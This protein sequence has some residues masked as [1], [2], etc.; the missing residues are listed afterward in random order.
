MTNQNMN[1]ARTNDNDEFYTLLSEIEL[2]FRHYKDFFRGK[3]IYCPCDDARWSNFWWHFFV[4][5]NELG[6]KSLD[7]SCFHAGQHGEH[8]HYEGGCP[9]EAIR[10]AV[11]HKDR[12]EVL[13]YCDYEVFE[14]EGGFQDRMDILK[15]TDLIATNPPFSLLKEFVPFIVN[16]GKEFVIIANNNC[17]T[18][19]SIWPLVRDGKMFGGYRVNETMEFLM[20]DSYELLG[21]AY[22]DDD[23]KKHGFVTAISWFTN[24]DISKRHKPTEYYCRYN[25][26]KHQRYENYD[27]I[28]VDSLKEIPCDW[29]GVMGVPIS[30]DKEFCPEQF[31]ILGMTSTSETDPRVEA[32]R[33]PG[34]KRNRGIIDGVEKYARILI[35]W[36]PEAMPR[37]NE[38][39]VIIYD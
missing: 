13:K 29:P 5:F 36:K 9:T 4:R 17:I 30:I 12:S 8:W 34:Q 15:K 7:A 32:I 31:E 22:L 35:R 28:N 26:E 38:K 18:L 11:W 39:G 1:K 14:D 6:L 21:K 37:I 16:A 23:G 25:P 33:I 27:A 20:P 3:R 10:E 19:K 2:E 24:L